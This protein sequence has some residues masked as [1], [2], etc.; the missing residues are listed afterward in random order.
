[1]NTETIDR[2]RDGH[3]C[4]DWPWCKNGCAACEIVDKDTDDILAVLEAAQRYAKVISDRRHL[5]PRELWEM[6]P[7]ELVESHDAL[8]ALYEPM[9][10]TK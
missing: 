5:T 10:A 8:L 2:F 7:D 9:E 3:R 1:M 4:L 6:P